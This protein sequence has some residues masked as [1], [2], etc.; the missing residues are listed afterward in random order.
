MN[1]DPVNVVFGGLRIDMQVTERLTEIGGHKQR[2]NL[3]AD[4][5]S[6]SIDH[7]VFDVT[8]ARRRGKTPAIDACD[9]SE[10]F[11][12]PA[13]ESPAFSLM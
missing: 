6:V 5:Q 13:K 11:E 12:A 3:D 2:S 4:Q 8:D 9:L 10:R 1:Q 7:D